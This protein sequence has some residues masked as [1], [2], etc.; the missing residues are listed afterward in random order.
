MSRVVYGCCVGSWDKLSRYVI[1]RIGDRPLIAISGQTN[2]ADAYNAILEAVRD[3]DPDMLILLH[4]DLE[5]LDPDAETKLLAAVSQPDVALAGIAG[6]GGKAGL[7]WWGQDPIGFQRTDVMTIDFGRRSG[8][9][10]LLEGSLLA[11]S[12][13]ATWHLSFD[14]TYPGFHGYDEVAMQAIRRG[15]RNLVVDI[16]THHHTQMGFKSVHSSQQWSEADQLYRMKWG[17]G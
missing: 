17:L 16:D 9:V 10:D 4:D 13:W 12:S 15:K 3:F 2:I 8:E 7:A 14:M 6:G 5:I 11:F 1:P